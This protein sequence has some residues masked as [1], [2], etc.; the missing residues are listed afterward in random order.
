MID[1]AIGE[2][3]GMASAAQFRRRIDVTDLQA[4]ALAQAQAEAVEGEMELT[5]RA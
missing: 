3:G 4:Q 1:P 2:I 5:A